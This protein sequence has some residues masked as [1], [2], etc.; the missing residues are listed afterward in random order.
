MLFMKFTPVQQLLVTKDTIQTA[1]WDGAP[2]ENART[3][4]RVFG[5]KRMDPSKLEASV[6]SVVP[7]LPPPTSKSLMFKEYAQYP[8][9]APQMLQEYYNG[10]TRKPA[11]RPYV[12]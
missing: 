3:T 9:Y 11:L 10:R 12:F 5:R 1:S 8:K 6:E 7:A 2:I 4:S